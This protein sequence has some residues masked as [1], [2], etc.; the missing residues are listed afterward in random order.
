[1]KRITGLISLLAVLTAVPLKAEFR[2]IDI[3]TFGMD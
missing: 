2:Q 3:T 1:M